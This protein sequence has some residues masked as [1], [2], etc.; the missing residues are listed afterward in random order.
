MSNWTDNFKAN[1]A[2]QKNTKKLKARKGQ[3]QLTYDNGY[4]ITIKYAGKETSITQNYVGQYQWHDWK[5]WKNGKT[6]RA[7]IEWVIIVKFCE[8]VD[9]FIIKEEEEIKAKKIANKEIEKIKT[10]LKEVFERECSMSGRWSSLYNEYNYVTYYLEIPQFKES[11]SKESYKS[12]LFDVAPE[13]K[14]QETLKPV[15]IE[16]E[17]FSPKEEAKDK[18]TLYS[19]SGIS[20]LTAGQV[21][22]IIEII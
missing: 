17:E 18:R 20:G 21:K 9:L 11:S 3:Y 1:L 19:F 13:E 12:S 16:I 8:A 2:K 5:I 14:T 6:V 4:D 10:R 15:Q 7:K 22:G